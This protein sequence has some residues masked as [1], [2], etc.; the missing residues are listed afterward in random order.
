MRASAER[1]PE[2][3]PTARQDRLTPADSLEQ[4]AS[5]DAAG[6]LLEIEDVGPAGLPGSL[7]TEAYPIYTPRY[8]SPESEA[9]DSPDRL[10]RYGAT[11]KILED[12]AATHTEATQE[13]AD[14]F[15]RLAVKLAA[16]EGSDE[17]Q[18]KFVMGVERLVKDYKE[19][20]GAW[21]MQQPVEVQTSLYEWAMERLCEMTADIYPT[22]EDLRMHVQALGR[23]CDRDPEAGRKQAKNIWDN[24]SAGAASAEPPASDPRRQLPFN[25]PSSKYPTTP[26]QQRVPTEVDTVNVME[27]M[28]NSFKDA[29]QAVVGSLKKDEDGGEGTDKLQSIS[30]FDY[31]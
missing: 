3:E 13:E 10:Y 9:G 8:R 23:H 30:N 17:K 12:E 1:A 24:S 27:N 18:V 22:E 14:R 15:N 16:L 11:Q 6:D 7:G 21:F 29:L 5:R 20:Y 26:G 31:K 25:S 4:R 2:P 19:E 28:S